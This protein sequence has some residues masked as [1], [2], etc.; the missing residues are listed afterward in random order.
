MPVR[1]AGQPGRP[2][3]ATTPLSST[4]KPGNVAPIHVVAASATTAAV[5]IA[6]SA[7]NPIAACSSPDR[8]SAFGCSVCLFM[9]HASGPCCFV[10]ELGPVRQ[11]A[12]SPQGSHCLRDQD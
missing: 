12:I 8:R 6:A 11:P 3:E 5:A 9:T 2:I 1:L 10:D 7:T 4:K